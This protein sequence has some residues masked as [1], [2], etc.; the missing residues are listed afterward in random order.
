M[1]FYEIHLC[2]AFQSRCEEQFI[3]ASAH[4]FRGGN[5]Y[6]ILLFKKEHRMTLFSILVFAFN[7]NETGYTIGRF[8][9]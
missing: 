7:H 5:I 4:V 2:L 1:L 3:C 9:I 8:K 6:G